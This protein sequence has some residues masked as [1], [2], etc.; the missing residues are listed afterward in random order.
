[1]YYLGV[2][3]GGMSVKAGIVDDK[4]NILVKRA[5]VTNAIGKTREFISDIIALCDDVV[6]EAGLS[7]C[8]VASVGI[9][10]PGTVNTD[11]GIVTYACNIDFKNVPLA[12]IF[13][14]EWDVPVHLAND[15]DAASLAE[16]KFG[17][18]VGATDAILVTLGTG[19]GTGIVINGKIFSGRGGAG[20]ESGHMVIVADGAE[21]GCGRKGCFEA[22][23]SASALIRMTAQA[24]LDN[25]DS[26]LAKFAASGIDG[27][28]AFNAY[29]EGD[30]VGTAV[31]A[32]YVKYIGI[33]VT[34][35]VNI[36]RP[37]VV[38]IGG[39]VS[40]EGDYFIKMIEEY[41][42]DNA[43]GRSVN[44][45]VPLR[46]AELGNDAGIIGAAALGM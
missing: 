26:L 29:K 45:Y 17:G 31:V 14:S 34:N 2:D 41:V 20:G 32:D 40:H 18:G 24:V 15:A 25:P 11:D 35:L 16:V 43:Y 23:A 27:K 30:A 12:S 36:F 10:M 44:P 46:R 39:G 9:G 38:L 6:K 22:Y 28:T 1:M 7:R 8:D 21:C 42:N 33:G 37:E 5:I 19:V 4:G 13:R 3:V